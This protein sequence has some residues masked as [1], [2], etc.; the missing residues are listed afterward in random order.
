MRVRVEQGCEIV[1]SSSNGHTGVAVGVGVRVIVGV[2]VTVGVAVFVTVGVGVGVTVAVFVGVDVR[3][4][5]SVAVFVGVGVAVFVALGVGVGVAHTAPA[6]HVPPPGH[7]CVQSSSPSHASG[8][9]TFPSSVFR[10]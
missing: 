2:G 9:Q 1:H 5:V 7:S 10:H 3:V 8:T 6:S 4:G